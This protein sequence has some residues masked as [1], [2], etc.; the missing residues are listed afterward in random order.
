VVRLK[1]EDTTKD[2]DGL[3]EGQDKVLMKISRKIASKI[4]GHKDQW[5]VRI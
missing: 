5:M 1:F 3:Y 2:D 4:A